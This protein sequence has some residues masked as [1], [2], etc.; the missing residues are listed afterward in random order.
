MLNRCGQPLNIPSPTIDPF[1]FSEGLSE[2]RGLSSLAMG[3]NIQKGM[4]MDRQ[5][6]L[7]REQAS[8]YL[9]PAGWSWLS[10]VLS[11][12][13]L[14]RPPCRGRRITAEDSRAGWRAGSTLGL[15]TSH[16]VRAVAAGVP[17]CLVEDELRDGPVRLA[18]A[19]S[20]RRRLTASLL[21]PPEARLPHLPD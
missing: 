19:S 16:L 10:A 9:Q 14:N 3:R 1:R 11:R 4:T 2:T 8:I 15:V 20:T 21:A 6:F 13:V 18:I 5:I 7:R 17:S 12:F